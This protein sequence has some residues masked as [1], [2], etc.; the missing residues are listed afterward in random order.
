MAKRTGLMMCME[1]RR[2][3]ESK[4]LPFHF[5]DALF[6]R[7]QKGEAHYEQ[8]RTCAHA[9]TNTQKLRFVE[10]TVFPLQWLY[11]ICK[12]TQKP[13]PPNEFSSE[14]GQ[15]FLYYFSTTIWKISSFCICLN[16]L[17]FK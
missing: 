6:I 4:P 8:T 5:V 10:Y 17:C 16:L 13:T 12:S 1:L 9:H 3:T 15:G 2:V 14:Q 7:A 11:S